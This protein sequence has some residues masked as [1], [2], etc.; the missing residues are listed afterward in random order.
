MQTKHYVRVQGHDASFNQLF[1]SCDHIFGDFPLDQL[2]CKGI[3]VTFFWPVTLLA[4]WHSAESLIKMYS[5]SPENHS[6]SCGNSRLSNNQ[7]HQFGLMVSPRCTTALCSLDNRPHHDTIQ[8]LNP[9]HKA[10]WMKL[11]YLKS[12]DVCTLIHQNQKC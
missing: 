6:S 8:I 3:T 11:F 2:P 1:L 10:V 9:L 12:S 5:S 7:L 4:L